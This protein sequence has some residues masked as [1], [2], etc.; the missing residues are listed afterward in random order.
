[1]IASWISFIGSIFLSFCM[2]PEYPPIRL[3]STDSTLFDIP[4]FISPPISLSLCSF[5]A[6]SSF[7]LSL[8]SLFFL[9]IPLFPF[10]TICRTT[11]CA[12]KNTQIRGICI[13]GA[14]FL[15]YAP[16]ILKLQKIILSFLSYH[17]F[18]AKI[19]HQSAGFL[20]ASRLSTR[21]GVSVQ[22]RYLRKALRHNGFKCCHSKS[23]LPKKNW[24]SELKHQILP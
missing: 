18:N 21:L 17:C 12:S 15:F 16:K 3:L 19:P 23:G 20:S 11:M 4:N 10:A 6:V 13:S 22:N 24:K 9:F 5:C 1:M 7:V 2:I 14:L 8:P